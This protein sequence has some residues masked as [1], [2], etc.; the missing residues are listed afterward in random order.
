MNLSKC[1]KQGTYYS[2]PDSLYAYGSTRDEIN[3]IVT[4]SESGTL[5]YTS[6]M[7]ESLGDAKPS[8]YVRNNFLSFSSSYMLGSYEIAGWLFKETNET[9]Y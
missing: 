7:N 4:I 6:W 8:C 9:Y 3:N 1:I 2:F 5:P